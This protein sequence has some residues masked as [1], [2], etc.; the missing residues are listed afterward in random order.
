M[1]RTNYAIEVNHLSKRFHLWHGKEP[2]LKSTLVNMLRGGLR[3]EEF[4]ALRNISFNVRKGE[5]LGVIGPNGS[6]KTTLLKILA[7]IIF[8]TN[9]EIKV[10]GR[11]STLFELGTGFHPDLTGRENIF[12]NGAVLGISRKELERKFDQIVDFSELGK[13]IEMPVKHYSSGMQVRLAFS[14][15]I[16]VSPEILLIDEVLA[17]GDAAFQQKSFSVFERFKKQGVTVIFVSHDLEGIEKFCDRVLYIKDS[18]LEASGSPKKTIARYLS[19]FGPPMARKRMGGII[20]KVSCFNSLGKE[21]YTFKTGEDLSLRISLRKKA[22]KIYPLNVGIA[23]LGGQTKPSIYGVNTILDKTSPPKGVE[24]VEILLKDLPLFSGQ[25]SVSVTI[26]G[27][28]EREIL[29]F[30]EGLAS[31]KVTSDRVGEGTTYI[32]HEWQFKS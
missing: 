12:L 15:A 14:V 32:D 5:A 10:D 28:E 20:D 11:V 25:Y 18:K 30:K 23:I 6:G 17:V 31:F 27:G 1:T 19:E 22:K 13:F 4:W 16:N 24:N 8:P 29:D 21:V 2:S 9:G 7:G 26:H 3:R